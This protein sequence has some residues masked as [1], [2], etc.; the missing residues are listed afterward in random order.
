MQPT[1]SILILTTDAGSGHRSAARAIEAA[2]A[3]L[4]GSD[5]QVTIR[6]PWHHD[7]APQLLRRY[8][9]L[10]VDEVQHAPALYHLG[11]A[12]SELPIISQLVSHG[13]RQALDDALRLLL[14]EHPVDLVISVY[15]LFTS[16]VAAIYRGAASRPRLMTVV[17]DL[18]KVHRS[19]FNPEDDCC[20]VPTPLA[21]R[22]ALRC[23]LER[24]RVVMTGI[25]VQP[26]FGRPRADVA[27]LRRDL[28]WR[29][30]LPTLLLLGGGA[31][32][33]QIAALAQALD[34][35]QL[36]LQLAVVAGTNEELA[37]QLRDY[38]WQ[39]PA[40]IYGFVQLAD[41]MHAADMVATKAGGLTVSEALAAG[42][43]LLIHGQPPGQEAGNLHYVETSDAG[44]W[45]PDP[46]AFVARVG[47]WLS[48][49]DELQRVTAAARR[50][51]KPEAA[52]QIARR[53]WDLLALGPAATS[54]LPS[55]RAA[56]LRLSHRAST[57]K[58][59]AASW[60]QLS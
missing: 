54:R 36:P 14:D 37:Q 19:W 46:D 48:H 44:Y 20:A 12:L 1:P 25:P 53:A 41:M 22:K 29:P 2:F 15:P 58:R 40:H 42:R 18:G 50:L 6:N 45:T 52:H 10:Y 57:R 39:I 7:S 51:G 4:Y 21:R 3:Q 24:N 47:R 35:A 23:G 27:R 5:A 56:R 60:F 59:S 8:E 33:G 34:T 30:D 38:P 32:V 13:L 9:E 26:D 17:T 11:Y 55:R 49:P 16:A 31:G 43:P 28:G